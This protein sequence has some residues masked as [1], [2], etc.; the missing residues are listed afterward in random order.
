MAGASAGWLSTGLLAHPRLNLFPRDMRWL[1]VVCATM[2]ATVTGAIVRRWC[3]GA[4]YRYAVDTGDPDVRMPGDRT[5]RHVIAILATGAIIGGVV[6]STCD[7]DL[8][9][10][11]GA[12]AGLECAIVFVPVGIAVIDAARRAQ[13]ARLGT[14]VAGSDRRAVWAILSTALATTTLEAI[15][16]WSA[17]SAHRAPLPLPALGLAV[18]AGMVVLIVLAA[19]RRALRHAE[20]AL[21]ELVPASG[22]L[23][24]DA[25]VEIDLGLGEDVGV[26]VAR[27]TAAYRDRDRAIDRIRG[28]ADRVRAALRRAI[29][30]GNFSTAAVAAIT[31]THLV[32]ARIAGNL[33]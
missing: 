13:R 20:L 1:A 15:P 3:V 11:V 14:L 4:R 26:H 17:A 12:I 29:R 24:D 18:V 8:A 33:G 21:V 31:L 10:L 32:V 6:G 30:R 16:D 28:D 25:P 7:V 19:D 27:S 23:A 2:L 9:V 5:V 22:G